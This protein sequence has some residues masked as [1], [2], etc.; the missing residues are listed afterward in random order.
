VQS[1]QR[2]RK[3]DVAFGVGSLV[4]AFAAGT[5]FGWPDADARCES[6]ESAFRRK[7]FR[8]QFK[9]FQP[10][11]SCSSLAPRVFEEAQ[12]GFSVLLLEMAVAPVATS[13]R[14][15]EKVLDMQKPSGK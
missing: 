5:R 1:K 12:F 2:R 8:R 6:P 9:T 13:F 14:R 10:P 11:Q 7:G 15:F 3:W 4:A